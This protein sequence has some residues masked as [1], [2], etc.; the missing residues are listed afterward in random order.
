MARSYELVPRDVPQVE[1]K[2]R[3]IATRFPVPESVPMLEDLRKAEPVSMQGQAPVVWDHAE[4][5][6]VFD[7]WGNKWLDFSSGVL[8]ANAGHGRREIIDAVTR[9]AQSGLLTHY[10]FPASPR[11]DLAKL[12]I[13]VAPPELNKAFILST[14]SETTECAIKLARQHGRNVG[15]DEK[16][17]TVSFEGAFHGRTLGAQLI[18]GIPALKEW[19]GKL[20]PTFVQVPHPDGW[21]NED[22]SFAGFEKALAAK[23]VKPEQVCLVIVETYQGGSGQF[24]PVEYAKALRAW[25]DK[26]KVVLCFDEVQAGFGRT[27]RMFGFE[28]YGVVPDVATLGKGISSSLP[29]SAIIGREDLMNQFPPGSMTSTH[30]G[31]PVCAAAAVASINL[32]RKE[33]L[34]ENAAKVGEALHDRLCQLS[35]KQSDVIGPV[36]GKGLIAAVHFVKP[37]T[38]QPDADLAWDV[39]RRCIESGVLL[40]SPVGLGG[41]TIKINPPLLI[42][43]EAAMEGC[44]VL[45]GS[46]EAALAAR[47]VAAK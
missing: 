8:V 10:C 41:G 15:G 14:G 26:N 23:G 21:R 47:G 6:Q 44:K 36:M 32:I 7:K 31:N 18:G 17:Y 39:V 42:T 1:T 25:C 16:V 46:L 28:H 9:T 12:L 11:R 43:E 30:T 19:I 29:V 40:F 24:L 27:G 35:R 37:G 20:D 5:F 33:N 34:V 3:R 38:K 22:T 13:E 45:E 2:Y 4:G